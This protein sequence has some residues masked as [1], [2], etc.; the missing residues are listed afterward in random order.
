MKGILMSL[1]L[2]MPQ[3]QKQKRIQNPARTSYKVLNTSL[4][5]LLKING[6][7]K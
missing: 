2:M 7:N 4:E 6:R 5:N 1:L 3:R